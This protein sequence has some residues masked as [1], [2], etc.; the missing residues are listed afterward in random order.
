MR[1]GEDLMSDKL[2]RTLRGTV[3]MDDVVD[4]IESQQAT[5]KDLRE[6]CWCVIGSIQDEDDRAYLKAALKE[7]TK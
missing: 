1:K 4:Y 3:G 5:I 7:K 2:L 6:A